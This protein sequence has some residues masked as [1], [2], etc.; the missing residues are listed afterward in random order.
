VD[1]VILV[2][3]HDEQ[4]GVMEKM[5]AHTA[6]LLHRAFSVIIFNDRHEILLQQRAL[7]KYHSG[8]LWTNT[9]CSHPAPNEELEAAG[10]RRLAEEMGFTCE[11]SPLFSF[12]YNVKL[13][14]K[15]FEHELD[16]VFIGKYQGDIDPNPAEVMDVKWMP[17]DQL[18]ADCTQHPER[19][20]AWFQIILNDFATEL[21]RAIEL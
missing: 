1:L 11:I 6:G 7:E 18:I 19:Y 10:K 3:E 4:L 9:C 2:N 8:G 14:E 5:E 17:F 13:S 21:K 12:I 20:T 15:L 16:H